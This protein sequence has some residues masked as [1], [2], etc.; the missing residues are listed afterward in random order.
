MNIHTLREAQARFEPQ[1]EH[2]EE[3][4]EALHKLRRQFVRHFSVDRLAR[5]TKEEYVVGL[6][7]GEQVTFCYGIERQLDALGRILGA[8]AFKFGVYFGQ[9]K[10]DPTDEYR[11]TKKFG[12]TVDQAFSAVRASVVELI[13]AGEMND[14]AAIAANR[15][16]PM[17]K[18]KILSTYFEDVYLNVFSEEHLDFFLTQLDLDTPALIRSD[19]FLKKQALVEF[20]NADAVMSGWSV[21][22]FAYFLYGYYPGRP[23]DASLGEED[24]LAPYR[25]PEFPPNPTPELISLDV[26]PPLDPTNIARSKHPTKN[27]DYESQARSQKLVGDRGEKIVLD[28]ERAR[29]RAAGKPELEARVHKANYDYLGFD[30][31]SFEE[32][33]ADRYIEVKTTRARAGNIQF[34]LTV[35]EWRK[36]SE[37]PNYQLYIVFEILSKRPKIWIVGNPFDPENRNVV[38]TPV[39]YQV[40]IRTR[41]A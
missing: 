21:D 16:S 33:G 31:H 17:F 1:K 23:R 5:M 13:A 35:N 39:L 3:Q 26:L 12:E 28:M 10:S 11:F 19:P 20:K 18:G 15:L 41:S 8:N 4:R 24:P 22:I 27:P 9:T 34:F 2:V 14:L 32:D 30:I 6:G 37:L 38:K 7:R 25:P 36:A 40:T 29:L